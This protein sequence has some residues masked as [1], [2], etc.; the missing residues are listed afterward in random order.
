L[1]YGN[2]IQRY[3]EPALHEPAA[4]SNQFAMNASLEIE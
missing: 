4:L 1:E 2:G 3:A